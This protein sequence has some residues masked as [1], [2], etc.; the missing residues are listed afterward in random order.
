MPRH[1]LFLI[2]LVAFVAACADSPVSPTRVGVDRPS[3]QESEGRGVFQR[4]VALGT[5][6]SMGVQSDGAFFGTQQASWP[7]QLSRMAGREMTQPYIEFPGCRSPIAPPL[8]AGVRLSGEPTLLAAALLSCAP[9]VAGVT[10]PTQNVALNGARVGDA[11]FT[12]PQNILDAGNRLVYSRV[13]AAGQTQVSAMEAQNPKIVSV[14]FGGNE[15]LSAQA[16]VALVGAPPL[17]I[18]NPA[19]FAAQYDQLLDRIAAAR[20]KHV[21]LIGL[22]SNPFALPGFRSGL[23]IW[24]N[25][26]A[27]LV[28]FNV[29]VQADCG[30]TNAT[31]QIFVTVKLSAAIQA[32]LAARAA[33]QPPVPFTCAGAGPTTAD[34]V[35]TPSEQAIVLA[36]AAQM[37]AAIQAEA[38]ARGYALASLDALYSAPGVR[39]P[40]NVVALFTTAEPFGPYISLDGIHPNANGQA[41]IAAAAAE[42]LNA[43]YDLGIPLP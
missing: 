27:L 33:S 11:L 42:A 20:V 17:P 3:L 29:E 43:R 23:E 15:I 14:E 2:P 18:E 5:S 4:Y 8:G 30:T 25:A 37:N 26:Q 38:E 6:V 31:N 7:A 40:L 36:V 1:S 34:F 22:P 32:G 39:T 10:L 19:T 9:N 13:L 12:T 16:G 21:L 35:L 24:A 41:L 28:G